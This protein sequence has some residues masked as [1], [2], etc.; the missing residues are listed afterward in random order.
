MGLNKVTSRSREGSGAVNDDGNGRLCSIHPSP[1][2]PYIM[3]GYKRK[4]YYN[5]KSFLLCVLGQAWHR[6]YIHYRCY[7]SYG[8]LRWAQNDVYDPVFRV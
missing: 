3:K 1:S 6:N 8:H 4:Y 7:L 5:H 2:V